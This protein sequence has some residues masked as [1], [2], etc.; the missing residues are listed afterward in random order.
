MSGPMPLPARDDDPTPNTAIP[1]LE[2]IPAQPCGCVRPALGQELT[3]PA[4]NHVPRIGVMAFDAMG[5]V[6]HLVGAIVDGKGPCVVLEIARGTRC[7]RSTALLSDQKTARSPH[8]CRM[9]PERSA[10]SWAPG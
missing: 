6:R 3:S 2:D 10:G 7:S 5:E 4:A 1:A 9:R 8:D